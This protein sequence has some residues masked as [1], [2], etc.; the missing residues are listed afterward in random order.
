[1][2]LK[3]KQFDMN[4]IKSTDSKPVILVKRHTGISFLTHD[5]SGNR[6]EWKKRGNK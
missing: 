1:M 2:S 6:I 3:L 5:L 4:S